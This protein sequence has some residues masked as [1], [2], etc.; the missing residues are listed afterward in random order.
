[1]TLREVSV[2]R[3]FSGQPVCELV[4]GPEITVLQFKEMIERSANIPVHHQRLLVHGSELQRKSALLGQALA[5]KEARI[6][7]MCRNYERK[8]MQAAWIIEAI[9]K[10]NRR[11]Q[12]RR[13]NHTNAAN[14][15]A[16]AWRARRQQEDGIA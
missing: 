3:A 13:Y 14:A 11:P 5:E 9:W 6:E 1:M 12:P 15:I 2:V 16:A 4:I 8:E 7:L 10:R